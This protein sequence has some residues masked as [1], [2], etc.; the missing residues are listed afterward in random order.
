MDRFRDAVVH[1]DG[2]LARVALAIV[3]LAVAGGCD[4]PPPGAQ[5]IAGARDPI[6]SIGADGVR[7]IHNQ[8][9]RMLLA[10]DSP[11]QR[12]AELLFANGATVS[13][14][15]GFETRSVREF[16][17]APVQP[18]A[19]LFWR[20]D[21]S[22]ARV[23]G[24]GAV[25]VPESAFLGEL[26]NTGWVARTPDGGA[27]F[28]FATLPVVHRYD[29]EGRLVWISTRSTPVE[30]S[31]PALVVRSGSLFPDFTERQHGVAIGPDD[32]I[33]VLA[34]S[35]ST[36]AF[37]VDVLDADGR[38]LWTTRVP[39]EAQVHVA[40]DG[41]ISLSAPPAP[42]PGPVMDPF[43]LPA[44]DGTGRIRLDEHRGRVVVLNFWASWCAPCRRELPA[45]AAFAR[46]VD[47]EQVIVIGINEDILVREGRAFL[48]QLGGSPFAHA[49][50]GGG[51]R[52]V[53]HY[54]GLPYTVVLDR[55]HR[56]V[57][58]LY[59]FG[60]TIQPV[61]DAVVRALGAGRHADAS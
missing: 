9:P 3:V 53:V 43:D 31:P 57:A 13:A 20:L 23:S 56:T 16:A 46:E 24:I 42:R 35:V 29:R 17:L 38:W 10:V 6:T 27:V 7:R 26:I 48:D 39:R 41:A 50:G 49:A 55:E 37:H 30:P 40:P 22:G 59:G 47:P 34:A 45:L 52:D 11:A 33:H 18:D 60:E 44:L 4:R 58:E 21:G 36:N 61:R 51:M 28:A 25:R 14:E 15:A 54:R 19:P 5:P 1:G 2:V 32:R 12:D 8:G